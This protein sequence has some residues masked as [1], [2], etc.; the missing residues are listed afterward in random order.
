[1]KA[2]KNMLTSG[3]SILQR[4][5]PV[6]LAGLC[7]LA[8]LVAV[9]G[10]SPHSALA[11]TGD[12][13]TYLNG[14]AR[15]G[16]N[17]AE[18]TIT[19]TTAPN[20]KLHWTHVA[21]GGSIFS[22]PVVSNGIAYWGSLDGFEHATNIATNAKVWATNLGT[23]TG[24]CGGTNGVVSTA[25]IATVSVG[26]TS[27]T[28]DFVSGG[29]ASFYALNAATGAIIWRTNL[30]SSPSHF[31]W[32]SPALFNGSIYIGVASLGDCPLVQGQMVQMNASTGAIQHVFDVVPNGCIG[33]G[34]WGSPT[35]DE[36]AGLLF[37]VTGNAGSCSTSETMSVSIIKLH[38]ADLSFMS[39]WQVPPAEQ[40]SDTD[41][42]STPT[43]FTATINGT[44][45]SMVGV[46]NKNGTYYAFN[47]NLIHVGPVWRAHLAGGGACPTCGDGSIS[48]AAWD[49]TTLYAAG[50]KTTI[51]G[52]GCAGSLRAL[53]PATGGFIWEHCMKAGPVLGAVTAVP[54]VVVVGE[55]S[56]VIVVNAKT[57]QTLFR[58][59]DT[60]GGSAFFGATSISNG[61]LFAGN[62]D[63]NL[64]ALGL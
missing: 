38:A 18:T 41:F 20:L 39:S 53:N 30:G 10:P 32:S 19:P 54:G 35:I 21:P 33:G 26:G 61:M 23:T 34:V 45:T 48:P 22:Q 44:V 36:S 46:P 17:A 3:K 12:W 4:I 2:G 51:A 25:T 13:T 6:I 37:F 56:F 57:N 8:A 47:R 11:A 59:Q 7:I 52:V 29:D 14:N 50:G 31:L 16:F 28:V 40:L 49:G 15:T 24:S 63:D 43:L 27:T 55:G 1:M 42:G 60:K 9:S 62:M 5:H 58:F 64:Y